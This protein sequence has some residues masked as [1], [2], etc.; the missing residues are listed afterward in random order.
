MIPEAIILHFTYGPYQATVNEF[1]ESVLESSAHYII[2]RDGTI[3]QMVPEVLSANHVTCYGDRALCAEQCPICENDEGRLSEPKLRS[4]GIELVNVGRLRGEPGDF[5][6]PDGSEFTGLVYE[7]D[8]ISWGYRYW[9]D[10]PQAQIDTLRLLL[11]DLMQRWNIPLDR[12]LGHGDVQINKIDPGPA[13]NLT[14]DRSG[15]PER[16]AIFSSDFSIPAINCSSPNSPEG[17]LSLPQ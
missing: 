1:R 17:Y 7:D 9:E 2:D 5:R 14:W 4:I 10:F 16:D 3:T 6:N 15:A 8:L 13:L 11:T 12:I